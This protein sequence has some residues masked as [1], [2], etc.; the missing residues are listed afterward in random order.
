MRRHQNMK[1]P[2]CGCFEGGLTSERSLRRSLPVVVA[3][4]ERERPSR[5]RFAQ[6]DDGRGAC[7]GN[8]NRRRASAGPAD[9]LLEFP[10]PGR[11]REQRFDDMEGRDAGGDEMDARPAAPR[12]DLD[13]APPPERARVAIEDRSFVAI[14]EPDRRI[15]S[16]DPK[17]MVD[18]L[19]K[20][21]PSRGALVRLYHVRK[22]MIKNRR[23]KIGGDVILGHEWDL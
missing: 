9:R 20:I 4:D 11:I 1:R 8:E 18:L 2:H 16:V 10:P 14:D 5:A 3:V 21:G 12:A 17:R 22:E 15:A 13:S 7:L 6:T 19:A 23:F